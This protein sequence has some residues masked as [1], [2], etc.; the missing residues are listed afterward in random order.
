MKTVSKAILA[1]GLAGTALAH[2]GVH[3]PDVRARMDLMIDIGGAIAV[4]GK[5]AQDRADFDAEK[6]RAARASLIIHAQDIPGAF[7]TQ[8][9]DPMSEAMPAIWE[10]WDDF[11]AKAGGMAVAAEQM[12]ASSLEGVKAGIGALAR[13]CSACHRAYRVQK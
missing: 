4:V 8:A 13:S 12:D 5:M 10:N 1:M 11:V 9:S 6:A 2:S 3:D 7:K